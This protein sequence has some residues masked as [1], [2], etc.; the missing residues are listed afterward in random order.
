MSKC[1]LRYNISSWH[2]LPKCLS[3]TSSELHIK[4][5]DML[6][7]TELTGTRISIEHNRFGVLFATVVHASGTLIVQNG[8]SIP[9]GLTPAQILVEL[10]RYGFYV[11]YNPIS[12][13]TGA[14][15]EYL[16]VIDKLGY[17]KIRLVSFPAA[18]TNR[19]DDYVVA[20][21][22]E[23]NPRWINANYEPSAAEVRKAI[24]NGTAFNLSALS[25]TEKFSWSWLRNFVA[26]IKDVV[27]DFA[28]LGGYGNA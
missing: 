23:A 21:Q 3:N 20:F 22:V 5:A 28:N 16:L 11:T 24:C 8:Y 10:A 25:Q 9:A 4:V 7:N 15:I 18:D 17:D 13:L 12:E 26:N 2:Q 19:I 27:S 14:Q 6:Q 1:P